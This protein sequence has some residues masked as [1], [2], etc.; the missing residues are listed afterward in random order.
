MTTRRNSPLL[1]CFVLIA[2]ACAADDPAGESALQVFAGVPETVDSDTR[3]LIYLH[4]AIIE[5]QGERPTHPEFGVYEYRKILEEFAAR[6]LTVI[7]EVRPAGTDVMAYAATV[8]DQVR[9]LQAGGVPPERITVVGF[10]KGGAIAI[11]T[12]SLLANDEVNF[13]FIGACGGW[14]DTR[15]EIVPRGRMLSLREASDDLVGSC[16]A[17]F[18]R[19]PE[20]SATREITFELGGGH[21]AFYR[22]RPEWV[23][24][25][26][27]WASASAP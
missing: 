8:V 2:A 16:G 13:V 1:V 15:P 18:L 17:L 27:E 20:K 10:S 4:G 25:V 6:G 22:P 24:P 9:G 23:D 5:R 3:Y 7:S 14:L 12:S 21:G 26:V 11:F 19:S